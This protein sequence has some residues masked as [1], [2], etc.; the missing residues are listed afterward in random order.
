MKV[1]GFCGGAIDALFCEYI[2]DIESVT[3]T[4]LV[5]ALRYHLCDRL[6]DG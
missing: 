3:S 5:Q 6:E 1:S 4:P 2:V